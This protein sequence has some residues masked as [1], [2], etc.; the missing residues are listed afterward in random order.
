MKTK[1]RYL[2]VVYDLQLFHLN[3]GLGKFKHFIAFYTVHLVSTSFAAAQMCLSGHTSGDSI[4]MDFSPF[5]SVGAPSCTCT[6]YIATGSRLEFNYVYSPGYYGC[7]SA[8]TIVHQTM[9]TFRCL[10]G[11]ESLAVAPGDSVTVQITR[12]RDVVD[13]KY[14]YLL[15]SCKLYVCWKKSST[16]FIN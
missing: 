8:I 14:C 4:L 15:R 10:Q 11:A 9:S 5:E 1:K 7:G 3:F 12:E 13:S 2:I 6:I 16:H